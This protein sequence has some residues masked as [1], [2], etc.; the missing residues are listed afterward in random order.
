M[1]SR[2]KSVVSELFLEI[3]I[4]QADP[5]RIDAP[6]V[7]PLGRWHRVGQL[8]LADV[9]ARYVLDV[10]I[11]GAEKERACDL[12]AAAHA[13]RYVIGIGQVGRQRLVGSGRGFPGNPREKLDLPLDPIARPGM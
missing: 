11:G 5:L 1:P 9:V 4:E 8:A 3:R 6:A 12:E 2:E 13:H 10:R 7:G